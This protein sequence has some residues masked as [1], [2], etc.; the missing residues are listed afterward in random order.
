MPAGG[1]PGRTGSNV[2]L[3]AGPSAFILRERDYPLREV[4]NWLR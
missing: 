1:P 3:L 4:P 2:E